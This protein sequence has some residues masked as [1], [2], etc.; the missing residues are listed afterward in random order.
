LGT[1]AGLKRV[2]AGS[3]GERYKDLAYVRR[4]FIMRDHLRNGIAKVVNALFE[5][6]LPQIWG[7]G[8][9]ACASDS[10][11]FGAWDQNLMTDWHPRHRAAGV[12]IYWH[13]DKKAACIYSQLKHPFASEVAAMMAGLLHHHTTMQVERNYV[14]THGQSEIAFGFCYVLNFKLMPR[15][16][17]IHRQKLYRPERGKQTAYPNLQ[18]VL[19]RP[20]NWERIR[21]E[22]DQIIK[23]ASALR[24][25]T[26][27][28]DAILRRFSRK[29]F[30]HPTFKAL[31]ELGRAIKTI[32][33]C[34]YLHSEELRREI[35]EGLQ[36]VENWN[37]TNDFIFYGKGREFSTNKQADMEVAMLCLHLLQI[38]MVFI[39]TLL[40]QE[41]LGEPE[42]VNRL[43]RDDLRALTPLI[44][45]HVNPYG[46]FLLDLSQRLPLKTLAQTA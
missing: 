25:R 1:N 19:K 36:V 32:F 22:Y 46:I 3:P 37:G 20:I 39:N 29:N 18:S 4:R 14:D 38:S 11:L 41:L 8:T 16:K 2:C 35:H 43:T 44:Y 21:R 9:T 26:A 12:K 33:I 10:K 7:E 31:I 15:F 45:H 23:Y 34:H 5:A 6:R 17:A 27:E 30:R 42:W 40:I 13:V 24:L 28:T